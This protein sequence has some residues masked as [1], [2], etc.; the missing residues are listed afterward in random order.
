MSSII[1]TPKDINKNKT[2]KSI[3]IENGTVVLNKKATFVVKLL[4][5]NNILLGIEIVTLAGTDYTNWGSDDTYITTYVLKSLGLT[6]P[7]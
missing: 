6:L 4:G 3:Q 7:Q 2:I 1:V 5:D